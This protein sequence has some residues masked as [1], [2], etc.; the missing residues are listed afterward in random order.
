MRGTL[1]PLTS[2]EQA[3]AEQNLFMVDRFLASQHLP[4]AE[5]YDV[6]I[7]RYL[8]TVQRWFRQP[9][10]YRYSFSTIAWQAMRSAVGNERKKQARRIQPISLDDPVPGGDG[11]TWGDT[12]T[13]ENLIYF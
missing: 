5:W 10:L 3:L 2:A 13:E 7:F 6:V 12:I 11:I 4:A 8:R 9:E 1:A